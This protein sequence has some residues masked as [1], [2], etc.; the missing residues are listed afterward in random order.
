MTTIAAPDM[1]ALTEQ[2][3]A[4]FQ[5]DLAAADELQLNHLAQRAE[6]R[7]ATSLG[8][9]ERALVDAERAHRILQALGGT[10]DRVADR[11]RAVEIRGHQDVGVGCPIANYL[12]L[13]GM[14]AF[15]DVAWYW[16]LGDPAGTHHEMPPAVSVF[17]RRFDDGMYLD[18]IDADGDPE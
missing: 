15:V 4:N 13:A 5:R 16:L 8:Q 12:E 14:P 17:I 3:L 9:R 1:A 10:A 6:G 2:V 11:L 18:L 7:Y